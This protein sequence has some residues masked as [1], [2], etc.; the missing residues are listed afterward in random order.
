MVRELCV[1]KV[2]R[3]MWEILGMD[4]L[5]EK[6]HFFAKMGKWNKEFG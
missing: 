4:V 5:L 1:F 6:V 3:D 2:V